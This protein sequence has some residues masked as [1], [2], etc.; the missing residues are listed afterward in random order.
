[1]PAC[2]VAGG[3][4]SV[5]VGS[6]RQIGGMMFRRRRIRLRNSLTALGWAFVGLSAA[7]FVGLTVST[8]T[9]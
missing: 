5:W 7:I 3:A 1:M 9:R 4:G 6:R 8:L 2:R